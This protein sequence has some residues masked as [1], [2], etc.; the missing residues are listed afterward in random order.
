VKPNTYESAYW[1][2]GVVN[3]TIILTRSNTADELHPFDASIVGRSLAPDNSRMIEKIEMDNVRTMRQ[4]SRRFENDNE[5]VENTRI[6]K[7]SF[8]SQRAENSITIT[9][10]YPPLIPLNHRYLSTNYA[11]DFL[12][13]G[14]RHYYRLASHRLFSHIREERLANLLY[15][16]LSSRPPAGYHQ[17]HPHGFYSTN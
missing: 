13:S 7:I 16:Y 14:G 17:T 11:A 1:Y 4:Y 3:V 5:K 10:T 12:S 8:S 9:P 15:K 6:S 2:Y